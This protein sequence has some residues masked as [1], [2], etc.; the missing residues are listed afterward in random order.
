[1]FL[2][3][4]GIYFFVTGVLSLPKDRYHQVLLVVGALLVFIAIL[5]RLRH[6]PYSGLLVGFNV[7]IVVE[8]IASVVTGYVRRRR[9]QGAANVGVVPAQESHRSDAGAWERHADPGPEWR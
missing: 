2:V 6:D 7:G 8:R 4:M 1:M 9:D 3:G 5:P